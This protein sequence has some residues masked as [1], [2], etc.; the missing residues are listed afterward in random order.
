MHSCLEKVRLLLVPK[1]IL[2]DSQRLGVIPRFVHASVFQKGVFDILKRSFD[3]SLDSY[4]SIKK[5][6]S[7]LD[8]T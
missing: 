6:I 7:T 2:A 8:I 3:S 1:G 4:F 5:L